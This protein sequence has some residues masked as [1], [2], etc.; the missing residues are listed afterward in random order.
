MSFIP[1]GEDTPQYMVFGSK[2]NAQMLHNNIYPTSVFGGRNNFIT[3]KTF[4]VPDFERLALD[5]IF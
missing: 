3:E 4:M 2:Q 1:K 5:F